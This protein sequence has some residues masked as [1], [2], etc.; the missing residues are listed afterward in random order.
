MGGEEEAALLEEAGQLLQLLE[1]SLQLQL[2]AE[3]GGH[4]G[5]LSVLEVKYFL[6]RRQRNP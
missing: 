5:E 6:Q 1:L 4:L 2:P 3:S